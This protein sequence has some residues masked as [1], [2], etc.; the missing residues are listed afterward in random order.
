M[1]DEPPKRRFDFLFVSVEAQRPSIVNEPPVEPPLTARQKAER[2]WFKESD[3][4]QRQR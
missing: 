2:R 3:H 1:S 4:E